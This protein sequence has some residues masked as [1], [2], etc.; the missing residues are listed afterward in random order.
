MTQETLKGFNNIYLVLLTFIRATGGTGCRGRKGE[1]AAPSRA[2]RG[3]LDQRHSLSRG[4]LETLRGDEGECLPVLTSSDLE[5]YNALNKWDTVGA[6]AWV[7]E[8]V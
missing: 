8:G 1:G 6:L 3:P 7:H 4:R 2:L 5:Q